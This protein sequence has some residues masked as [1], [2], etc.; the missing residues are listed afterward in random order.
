MAFNKGNK[1]WNK[2]KTKEE[3]PQ[4]GNSGVKKGNISWAKGKVFSK[5]YRNKLSISHKGIK[6]SDDTKNKRKILME[7][8]WANGFIGTTGKTFSE[9]TRKKMSESHR[10]D[11]AY[12]WKGGITEENHRLR[13]SLEYRLWRESVFERDDYTCLNCNIR[14]GRLNADHIKPWSLYPEL[15]FAID[16]GRTLCEDCHSEIGWS[17]FKEKNPRKKVKI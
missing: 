11:K 13:S 7:K 5:E 16:N 4:L 1:P 6:Q 12:Q 2:N 8:M 14:G 15:R 10:G 17:L 9:E 3:L